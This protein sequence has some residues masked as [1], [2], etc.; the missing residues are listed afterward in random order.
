[1]QKDGLK[2]LV[3]QMYQE[4][5]DNINSNEHPDKEQIVEFLENAIVS[6]STIDDSKIDSIEHAKTAFTNAYKEI[7]EHSLSS[8]HDTNCRFEEL[9]LMQQKTIDEYDEDFHINFPAIKSKFEE[10]QAHMDDEVKKANQ[11][12]TKLT[13]KVQQLEECSNLDS[14]TK[15]YNRRALTSYIS[16]ICAK[17]ELHHDFHILILDID[18]FKNINDSYGHIAGDKILIF[19][20]NILRKTLRDGDKVFRYGGEE[21][22]ITLNRID[23][24]TCSDV[25]TRILKLINSNKLIYK[26]IPLTVTTSIGGTKYY[27]GDTP[28]TII[29]R[30]DTALYKSKRNGKNQI[31]MEVKDGN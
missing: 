6:I 20:A 22:V 12:I 15:V 3:T 1:M 28:D 30:A 16:Q 17:E 14:L 24:Q 13:K 27:T 18:D 26:G 7:V 9:T 21:F 10:I 2:S 19:I 11:I 29:H 25:A 5:I 4:L 8:Y 23:D 31:T